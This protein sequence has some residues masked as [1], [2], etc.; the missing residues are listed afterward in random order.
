M[1]KLKRCIAMIICLSMVFSAI[2]AGFAVMDG[3]NWTWGT[4]TSVTESGVAPGAIYRAISAD[5]S[6]GPQK[7]HAISFDP[8]NPNLQLRAGKSYGNVY[9]V[10]TVLGITNEMEKDFPGQ[11]VAGINGDYFDLGVGVP[12]GVFIDEG[13]ILSTPPQYSSA[14]GIKNDGTPFVISHGTILNKILHIGEKKIELSGVNNRIKDT[15]AIML[16]TDDYGASTK[17]KEESIEVICTVVSGEPRHGEIMQ[18]T[19]D[20]VNQN[21]GNASIEEGKV[22]ISAVGTHINDLAYLQPGYEISVEFKFNQFWEDVKFAI[23]GNYTILKDGEIQSTGDSSRNPRTVVGHKEDGTV[24]FYTIDGRQSGYSAGATLKQAAT[25][26]KDMGCVAALNLDGGGSTTFVL[27]PLGSTTRKVVN[28]PSQSSSRQVANALVLLNTAEKHDYPTALFISP[29]G[30]KMLIGGTYEYKVSGAI[31]PNLQPHVPEGPFVWMSDSSAG[32]FDENGVFSALEAGTTQITV[33]NPTAKGITTAQVVD[34]LTQITYTG[35]E[36]IL[37][38]NQ[39]KTISVNAIHDGSTVAHSAAQ[40]TWSADSQ[41]GTFTSPGVILPA[42][43]YAEGYI[44]VSYNDTKLQIPVTVNGER[45]KEFTD[46]GEHMWASDAVYR[47]VEDEIIRGVT[48]TTFAPAKPIKRADFMLL[49]VRMM[50]ID[51]TK[52]PEDSFADV[53]E[54]AYYYNELGTAKALGIANGVSETE[55]APE[56]NIT[57]QEMF[58]LVWRVMKQMNYL[59]QDAALS[60]LDGYADADTVSGYARQAIATL[61]NMGFVQGDSKSCVNPANPA[62]RAE[63]AVFIDRVNTRINP[64]PEEEQEAPTQ[65]EAIVEEEPTA[66]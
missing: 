44:Y 35:G 49:L 6:A 2:P 5:T 11:V 51:T 15:D 18:L 54:S 10:Q 38:P 65:E 56:R 50:G 23:G 62:T 31:D 61:S 55:F 47:L 1:F 60:A 36:L 57:R 43:K 33:E 19:V 46:L 28:S 20:S 58:T 45:P 32:A 25:I 14:F 40:L 13:K 63:A 27:R 22:V 12:F 41:I 34:N 3:I 42:E 7:I 26:M 17:V 52:K 53:P 16:Y 9:G 59:T 4:V 8:K 64:D 21:V 30:Q 48:Q 29:G 39:E 37:E 24:V 66:D